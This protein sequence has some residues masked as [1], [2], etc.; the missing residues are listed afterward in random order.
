MT[1]IENKISNE[2]QNA[3][4]LIEAKKHNYVSD[5][6]ILAVLIH[7]QCLAIHGEKYRGE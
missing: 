4:D 2:I 7:A 5:E 6:Q 3:I 1:Q